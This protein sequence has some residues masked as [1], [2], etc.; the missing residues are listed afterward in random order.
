MI[1]QLPHGVG[2]GIA[3]VRINTEIVMASFS[4]TPHELFMFSQLENW[5]KRIR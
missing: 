5:P 2:S 3:A 4:I 1:L